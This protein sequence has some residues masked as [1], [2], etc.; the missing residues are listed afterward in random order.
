VGSAHKLHQAD[1]LGE[2]VDVAILEAHLDM[3]LWADNADLSEPIEPHEILDTV[4]AVGVAA[5]RKEPG[6]V[7]LTVLAVA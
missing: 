1:V 3:V 5:C 7:E 4:L 2:V 6:K